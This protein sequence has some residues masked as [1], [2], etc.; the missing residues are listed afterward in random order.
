MSASHPNKSPS[1]GY[2]PWTPPGAQPATR[3]KDA[4]GPLALIGAAAL[5]VALLVA[6]VTTRGQDEETISLAPVV[7]GG[8]GEGRP[9]SLL[10]DSEPVGAGVWVNG[11]S[12]GVTPAWLAELDPG[13]VEV[14]LRSEQIT[15]DTTLALKPGQDASVLIW[16]EDQWAAR[17]PSAPTQAIQD[18]PESRESP[19]DTNDGPAADPSPAPAREA[20]PTGRLQITTVPEGAAVWVA[21]DRLGTTPL[22]LEALPAGEQVVEL[23][24][25]G[26]ES[27]RLL[28]TISPNE[29]TTQ[30][31]ELRA[32]PGIVTIAADAGS[33]VFIN[34]ALEGTARN[35][36]LRLALAAGRYEVRV[37]HPERGEAF[38]VIEVI[39][40]TAQR[41]AFE[42]AETRDAERPRRRTGW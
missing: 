18:R 17:E 36:A 1:E 34:G 23:R 4:M 33:Q 25:P 22:A 7:A 24:L 29:L 9:A 35:G 15:H 39:A 2:V 27:E 8:G 3:I 38:R 12:V 11:D 40:G 10:I 19:A 32:R 5:V 20:P 13:V 42:Q 14:V 28:L 6:W 16:L 37:F 26:H 30:L 41:F 31:V 21:G